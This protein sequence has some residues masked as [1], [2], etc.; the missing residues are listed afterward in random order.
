MFGTSTRDRA[1]HGPTPVGC[2]IDRIRDH[3]TDPTSAYTDLAHR[4]D[5]GSIAL[6]MHCW[7]LIQQGPRAML[8][9]V[10][11][12][13]HLLQATN[14]SGSTGHGVNKDMT[15]MPGPD[16]DSD[17]DGIPD[18]KE[19]GD[20]DNDGVLDMFDLDSDNDGIYDCVE[21]GLNAPHTNGVLDGP[22]NANGI[23]VVAD[24]DGD[25]SVDY[26][27]RD[28][29]AD[30]NFDFTER[31]SDQ[32]GCWDV[33]E[34]GLDDADGD[35]ILGSGPVSVDAQ[36]RITGQGGYTGTAAIVTDYNHVAASCETD[37]DGL[38]PMVDLDDD[39]DGIPDDIECPNLLTHG[40]FEYFTG[41]SDGN[42]IGIDISPWNLGPGQ[43]ANIVQV[44]GAGGYAYGQHG[45]YRDANPSTGDGVL[46]HYLDIASGANDIY[47]AFTLTVTTTITYSG[48]FSSRENHPGDGGISILAGNGLG[49]AFIDGTGL[50][51]IEDHGSSSL[52]PWEH[53][54]RTI[55]LPAGTYSYVV[56][57]TDYLNFDEAK[58]KGPCPDT[59]GDGVVDFLDLDSD[60][61]GIY[62]LVEAGHGSTDANNDGVIDGP[63]AAFG[64]NGL[65]DGV[66]TSPNSSLLNYVVKDSDADG[67]YDFT[68]L[69][70]DGDGCSDVTE[71]GFIDSNGDG[72]PG[73]APIIVD[74]ATGVVTSLVP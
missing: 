19:V 54:E 53:Y 29:D 37:G 27:I 65:F 28:T 52:T 12:I 51:S 72:T 34:A 32:D 16:L 38:N 70:S 67:L 10:L 17:D 42:N 36:G 47:Q 24:T 64:P 30:S 69:D 46:Q 39:N 6:V 55:T 66:E 15:I 61:D 68:E 20:T 21:S 73:T 58:I 5:H 35:G 56:A 62:D 48:A 8:L 43:Q 11:L 57:M 7:N 13:P 3:R 4:S 33:T 2:M 41:L 63:P 49:G 74:P 14:F 1:V 23:P 71:A 50:Q 25:G 44:D 31:D 9:L 18:T 22:V 26:V 45:P 40:D 60:N 59:D